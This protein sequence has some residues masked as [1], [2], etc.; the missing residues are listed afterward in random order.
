MTPLWSW[1]ELGKGLEKLTG[2]ARGLLT[3]EESLL[4][5]LAATLNPGAVRAVLG[6]D[7]G[8]ELQVR[9]AYGTIEEKLER[10]A[11]V[12]CPWTRG[13]GKEGELEA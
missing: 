3:A 8:S 2:V 9:A 4:G 10:R 11:R 13:L 5:M 6:L 7:E 12:L 1:S